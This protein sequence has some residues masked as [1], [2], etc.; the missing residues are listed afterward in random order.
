[1]RNS[2]AFPSCTRPETRASGSDMPAAV[3]ATTGTWPRN[4]PSGTRLACVDDADR[5]PGS[6]GTGKLFPEPY[7]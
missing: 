5:N 2:T 4:M 7:L 1:M 3:N 6:L